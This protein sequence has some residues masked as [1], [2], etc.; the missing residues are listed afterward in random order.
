MEEIVVRLDE[1][2]EVELTDV[3]VGVADGVIAFDLTGIIRG[4]DETQM[5]DFAKKDLVPTELHFSLREAEK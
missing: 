4:V 3:D 5:A 1:E 2:S